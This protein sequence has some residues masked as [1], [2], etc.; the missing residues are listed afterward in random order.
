MAQTKQ[1]RRKAKVI[2]MF[3]TNGNLKF[4]CEDEYLAIQDTAAS[5]MN[6]DETERSR[7]PNP[8]PISPKPSAPTSPPTRGPLLAIGSRRLLSLFPPNLCLDSPMGYFIGRVTVCWTREVD[9]WA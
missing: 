9:V 4:L 8:H 3:G 5:N 7:L 1:V 6:H 2:M